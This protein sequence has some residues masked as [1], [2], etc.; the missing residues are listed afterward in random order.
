MKYEA[1]VA[2]IFNEGEDKIFLFFL[3]PDNN[4]IRDGLNIQDDMNIYELLDYHTLVVCEVILK[5][6][7]EEVKVDLDK[8]ISGEYGRYDIFI[9]I[10]DLSSFMLGKNKS[11]DSDSE[12]VIERT[13][14]DVIIDGEFQSVAMECIEITRELKNKKED[15]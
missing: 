12:D 1:V 15:V 8:F 3:D 9:H 6:G 10:K 4:V 5:D 2:K 14:E 7:T 13:V 11:S